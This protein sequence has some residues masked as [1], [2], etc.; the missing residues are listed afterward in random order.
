[1]FAS[2]SSTNPSPVYKPILP[3]K[4]EQS[5]KV[6]IVQATMKKT[7]GRPEFTQLNQTFITVTDTTANVDY[8]SS[9]VQRKW[10]AD[11]VLVTADGLRLDDSAQGTP[12]RLSFMPQSL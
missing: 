5:V 4:K 3:S 9:A 2:G 7:T 10:G 6:K 11:H 12:T 1:M 8:I